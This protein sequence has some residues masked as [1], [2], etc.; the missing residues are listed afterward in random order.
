[1]NKIPI[2]FR[3]CEIH[4]MLVQHITKITKDRTITVTGDKSHFSIK[5][6]LHLFKNI[7]VPKKYDWQADNVNE[8]EFL[9]AIMPQ[10]S[11][12]IEQIDPINFETEIEQ[13]K[14]AIAGTE[15][16][17]IIGDRWKGCHDCMQII[18]M[19]L[20][21]NSVHYS[22]EHTCENNGLFS[23]EIDFPTGIIVFDDWPDRF[24]EALEDG[25]IPGNYKDVNY[26]KGQR[27]QTE[28]YAKCNIFH[29]SVGNSSPSWYA[30]ETRNVIS[31]GGNGT[32]GF[33]EMG[34][35][36]T[37]L[38]WV[39]MV[40]KSLY[41]KII[42]KLPNERSKQF[43]S[44]ELKTATIK[45]GRWRFTTVPRIVENINDYEGNLLYSVAVW[46]DECP[47]DIPLTNLSK[48]KKL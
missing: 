22:C 3:Y 5:W 13:I 4:D 25:L 39:T 32:F 29:Q 7:D 31:I 6:T 2:S 38:W 46:I 37:D 47:K 17:T 21:G 23:V 35:F 16:Y 40:D 34:S 27:E 48:H 36:C 1:M 15:S 41:D 24:G 10:L 12:I 26:L 43:Y 18:N 33:E 42:A 11:S 44:N 20:N 14:A 28:E 30:N 8:T 19:T 45:P 9:R